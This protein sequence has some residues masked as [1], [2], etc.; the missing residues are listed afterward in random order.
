MERVLSRD[1]TGY[2]PYGSSVRKQAHVYGRLDPGP[3][4]LD[5]GIGFGWD[6]SGWLLTPFL[7]GLEPARVARL[8]DRVG[9]GADARRSPARTAPRSV[10]TTSLDPDV[11]AGFASRGTGQKYLIR[12]VARPAAQSTSSPYISPSGSAISSM[13]APSGSVK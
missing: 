8:R 13:R 6:V 9:R 11:I 2:S 1:L 4:E 3:L 5:L 10:S 7:A 12:P